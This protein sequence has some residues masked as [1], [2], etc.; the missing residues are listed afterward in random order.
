[1]INSIEIHDTK[2]VVQLYKTLGWKE[3]SIF[4]KSLSEQY[5]DV[6]DDSPLKLSF[7]TGLCIYTTP[8][9]DIREWLDWKECYNSED[10]DDNEQ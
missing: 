3:G 10:V 6:C 8:P 1:M 7:E 2:S 4:L 5:L 9:K